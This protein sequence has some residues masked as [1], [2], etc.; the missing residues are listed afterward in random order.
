MKNMS[1]KCLYAFPPRRLQSATT[2]RTVRNVS[3]QQGGS[4]YITDI[5]GAR[6]PAKFQLGMKRQWHLDLCEELSRSAPRTHLPSDAATLRPIP[7]AQNSPRMQAAR[8]GKG[9]V[10]SLHQPGTGC[11]PSRFWMSRTPAFQQQAL[12]RISSSSPVTRGLI[13]HLARKLGVTEVDTRATRSPSLLLN[14]LL[15]YRC[16]MKCL[17]KPWS[18]MAVKICL[19]DSEAWGRHFRLPILSTHGNKTSSYVTRPHRASIGIPRD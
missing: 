2:I 6:T 7:R 12:R 16:G 17:G 5:N 11:Y 3:Q 10:S 13:D 1:K 9:G 4:E 15:S 18:G 19:I 8:R 14:N